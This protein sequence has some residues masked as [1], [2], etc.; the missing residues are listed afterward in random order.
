MG[1]RP[2]LYPGVDSLNEH[3]ITSDDLFSLQRDPGKTLVIGGGYIAIECAGFLRGLG[4]E[5]IMVNRSSFLR[6]MDQD[7]SFR[8]VDEMEANGVRVMTQTVPLGAKKLGENLYAVELKTGKDGKTET[9]EVNTILVAIGRESAPAKAGLDK[10]GVN[11]NTSSLKIVGRSD[12]KE[13]TNVDHIYAV[14]DCLQD[15]PELM[16]VA[17]KSGKLLAHRI[18]A[19]MQGLKEDHEIIRKHK[20]DYDHIPTTVFSETE[21][22]YVGLNEEEAIKKFGDENIEVYHREVTPLQFSIV[23]GNTKAAYMKVIILKTN[24]DQVLGI[25]YMGPSADEVISGYA[26]AMKLGLRKEHL[27]S[28]LGVHP[29]TSED[30]FNLEVT[31]RSGE[32]YSKTDC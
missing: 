2:R 11:Y 22:S 25:H 9:V 5:V 19:R 21:Y 10:A 7:M 4:K 28:S 1:N 26:V 27:D 23:S 12:E 20:M 13:R 15:V 29:S 24:N 31:K 32:D 18:Y 17:Q 16:P 14:G 30:L 8:I 3:A 6:V